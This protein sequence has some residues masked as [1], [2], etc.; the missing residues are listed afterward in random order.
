MN[1]SKMLVAMLAM[2]CTAAAQ[3]ALGDYKADLAKVDAKLQACTNSGAASNQRLKACQWLAY[4]ETDK[5]LNSS[6]QQLVASLKRQALEDK[7][8][9]VAYGGLTYAEETLNRLVASERAWIR[10][11]DAECRFQGAY[12]LGGTGEEAAISDCLTNM[13]KQRILSI[14]ELLHGVLTPG[15]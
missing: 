12:N 5:I 4:E 3:G 8:T 10:F 9:R 6:Y 11:R 15:K 13:T 2:G 14:N 7:T 1:Q